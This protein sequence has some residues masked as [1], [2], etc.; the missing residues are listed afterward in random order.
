MALASRERYHLHAEFAEEVSKTYADIVC[1]AWGMVLRMQAGGSPAR[2]KSIRQIAEGMERAAVIV[3][4]GHDYLTETLTPEDR[5]KRDRK[6]YEVA[7]L[8]DE[9]D[10]NA[11][12]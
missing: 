2:Q 8:A 11:P 10:R 4:K 9:A 5:L 7:F 1:E 3:T 12:A 6:R